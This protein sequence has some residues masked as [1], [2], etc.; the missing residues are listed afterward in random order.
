MQNFH[1]NAFP[2][3]EQPVDAFWA[4]LLIEPIEG[5]FDRLVFAVAVASRT[6]FHIEVGNRLDRLRCLYDD[7]A[8]AVLYAIE[9]SIRD[10]TADLVRRS[11]DAIKEPRPMFVGVAI[12]DCRAG[13]GES[14]AHIGKAWMK[15]LSS[16]YSSPEDQLEAQEDT[17][18]EKIERASTG[19]RLPILIK[20]Y[21]AERREGLLGFF[22]EDV[23]LERKRRSSAKGAEVNIDFAGSKLVANFG[24]LQATQIT[25]S[26]NRIK[27][28]LWEL[29][30]NRDMDWDRGH[31]RQHQMIIQTPDTDDPQ[32]SEKQIENLQ[33]AK[34]QLEKQADQ[35][36]LLLKSMAS[37][38]Q[39]GDHLLKLEAA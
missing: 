38:P 7:Q 11:I 26:A 25:S 27:T 3:F 24:T 21:V 14:L 19:D 31:D 15:S 8:E 23:R 32:F 30:V 22:S 12:G 5:A 4:P 17:L 9:L 20:D 6:H 35:E 16:L 36:E 13:Q 37:V 34:L 18:E 10:L 29:K 39:I 1:S 2:S 28:R 33:K